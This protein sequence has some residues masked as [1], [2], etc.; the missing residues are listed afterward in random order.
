MPFLHPGT[1]IEFDAVLR[2][3]Q[4]QKKN[5][6]IEG[7]YKVLR[8][9]LKYDTKRSGFIGLTQYVEFQPIN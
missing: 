5:R 9:V 4:D 3:P 6:S 2:D 7:P 1:V 8:S